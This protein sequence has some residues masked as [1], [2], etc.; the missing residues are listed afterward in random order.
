M[1]GSDVAA[2]SA[3]PIYA[4]L[5]QPFERWFDGLAAPLARSKWVSMESVG[6]DRSNYGTTR[7]VRRDARAERDVIGQLSLPAAFGVASPVCLELLHGATA[8]RYADI[9]LRYHETG[10]LAP[11][12]AFQALQGAFA[13]LAEVPGAARAVGAV[14]AAV[15]VVKPDGPEYDVSYSDPAVPFSIFVGID[16]ANQAH[17]ELRLAES[18][19][20]ECMH[21]QLTLIEES[22]P[23]VIGETERYHSA[24]TGTH[25]PARGVMHA[26]Y[27]FRAVQDFFR[28]LLHAGWCDREEQRYLERRLVAIDEEVAETGDMR[29]SR[30]LTPLGRRFVCCLMQD[31]G[32]VGATTP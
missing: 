26:L 3:P 11:E 5:T 12:R 27:V 20:H 30:D 31:C 29:A 22:F 10:E 6:L 14:L 1:A 8:S 7:F 2:S 15:H 25:R 32:V 21:L 4:Y 28:A 19:L 9:G 16:V 18:I 13:R 17:G 23:L 24:W